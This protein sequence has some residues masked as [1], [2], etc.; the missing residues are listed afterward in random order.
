[1]PSKSCIEV[2]T[3]IIPYSGKIS[4]IVISQIFEK[5]FRIMLKIL[6]SPVYIFTCF[7][8]VPC[9]CDEVAQ[10][11]DKVSLMAKPKSMENWWTAAALPYRDR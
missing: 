8:P 6:F 5:I 3:L 10:S 2:T 4:R 1:M 11:F 9:F 7:M